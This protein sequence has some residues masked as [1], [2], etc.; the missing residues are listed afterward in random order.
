MSGDSSNSHT[1]DI[2]DFKEDRVSPVPTTSKEIGIQGGSTVVTASVLID[3]KLDEKPE[4]FIPHS[5]AS[6]IGDVENDFAS[7]E[8]TLPINENSTC[9]EPDPDP[10]NNKQN[11]LDKLDGQWIHPKDE[12]GTQQSQDEENCTVKCLYYTLQCCE[13]TIM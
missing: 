12:K 13:C 6:I 9:G 11:G 1:N 5:P 3:A 2:F 8:R 7:A 10:V 4:E